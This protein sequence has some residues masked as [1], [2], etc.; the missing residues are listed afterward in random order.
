MVRNDFCMVYSY[1]MKL[2]L[3]YLL[4]SVVCFY[5]GLCDTIGK[6]I[7]FKVFVV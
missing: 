5:L 3:Y 4:L 7:H 2:K 6:H 1:G